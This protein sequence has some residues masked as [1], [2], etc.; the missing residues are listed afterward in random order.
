MRKRTSAGRSR[1]VVV[2]SA[3]VVGEV[4]LSGASSSDCLEA[5]AASRAE[6]SGV[7]RN[8]LD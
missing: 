6:K 5:E 7:F 2:G 4:G 1:S 8:G 3:G